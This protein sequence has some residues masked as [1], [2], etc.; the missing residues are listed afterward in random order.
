MAAALE[1]LSGIGSPLRGLL[2]TVVQQTTLIDPP[3]AA[4]AAPAGKLAEAGK[5]FTDTVGKIVK[6]LSN[7][8]GLPMS[9]PGAMV[10][11]HFQPIHRLMAGEAGA[12]PIDV[13]LARVAE[14]QKQIR[15]TGGGVGDT[16]ALNA[17]QDPALRDSLQGL[18]QA[19][20]DMPPIF[21][22]LL[23]DVGKGTESTV[24]KGATSELETR[25]REDVL[26]PCLEVVPDRYPFSLNSQR[27]VPLAD[28]RR[29]FGYGGVYDRFFRENLRALVDTSQRPW[30]WREGSVFLS[31]G[32]L[33]AFENAQDI[34]ELFF[35]PD[36]ARPSVDFDLVLGDTDSDVR[37]FVLEIDGTFHE[38]VRGPKRRVQASW[39]GMGTSQS[40]VTFEDR[41]GPRRGRYFASQWGWFRVLDHYP[42]SR[43]DTRISLSVQDAGHQGSIEVS[44][45]SI[46]NPLVN[47]TWQRFAC[48][49]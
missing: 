20:A 45:A 5:A 3:T 33:D 41:S 43:D 23:R 24:R 19:A 34:R 25:Y 46:R 40:G 30:K 22:S 16:T 13:V 47:R 38:Y 49:S 32:M 9:E 28:F 4:P 8:A 21:Q 17:L 2:G 42:S 35:K 15:N 36:A 31:A 18:Q 39:P 27:E 48:G 44:A 26:R 14:V 37:R 11:A 12:A 29:L 6:P 10:T 1:T 7:A